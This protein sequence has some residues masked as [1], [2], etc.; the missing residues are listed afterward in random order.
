MMQVG[1]H[2]TY[3]VYQIVQ[4]GYSRY[5]GLLSHHWPFDQ[6]F[7]R[8][9]MAKDLEVRRV[10]LARGKDLLSVSSIRTR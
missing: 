10:D 1:T 4:V 8:Q 3:T 9:A 7:P 2:H 5:A 6:L